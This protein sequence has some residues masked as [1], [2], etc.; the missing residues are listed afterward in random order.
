MTRLEQALRWVRNQ[1][2][3]C[4]YPLCHWRA[5]RRAG[6]L[7]DEDEDGYTALNSAGK[8]AVAAL[9]KCPGAGA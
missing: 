4:Q 6:Y 5:L 1:D 8:R 9:G 2:D 3:D 7:G